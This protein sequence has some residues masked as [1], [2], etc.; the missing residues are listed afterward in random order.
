MLPA[1]LASISSDEAE[2]FDSKAHHKAPDTAPEGS[3]RHLSNPNPRAP[4]SAPAALR[5]AMSDPIEHPSMGLRSRKSARILDADAATAAAALTGV[6]TLDSRLL[7]S[8]GLQCRAQN[9]PLW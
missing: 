8:Y 1:A 2:S 4:S 3:A 7:L 9:R 6:L 5:S